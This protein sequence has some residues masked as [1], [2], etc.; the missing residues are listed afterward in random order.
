[1]WRSLGYSIPDKTH[2]RAEM[3]MNRW[4]FADLLKMAYEPTGSGAHLEVSAKFGGLESNPGL[5][6]GWFS[7]EADDH[8]YAR[9]QQWQ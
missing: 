9:Q 6:G 8:P 5:F 4:K 2:M 1:M 3:G 7:N